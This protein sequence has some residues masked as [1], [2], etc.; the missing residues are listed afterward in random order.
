MS[1]A[2]VFKALADPTRREILRE[3][4]DGEMA[5]GDIAARFDMAAPSVSRHLSILLGAG[6]IRQR[7]DANRLFYAVEAETLA[8]ALN[9]FLSAVCP[10]QAYRRR[11]RRK[12]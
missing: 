8:H 5:A 11:K 2:S 4:G 9:G 10:T 6:L 1:A 7:R 12:A 3:L